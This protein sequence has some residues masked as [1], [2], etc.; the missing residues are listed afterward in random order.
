MK[1]TAI[2][3]LLAAGTAFGHHMVSNIFIDGIDQGPGTCLRPPPNTNP[4]KDL[5][6]PQIA[7]NVGGDKQ[8]AITCPANA[9]SKVTFKWRAWPS[10]SQDIPL[11]PSH[12][13][14]CSVYMKRMGN[15]GTGSASGGGWFKIWNDGFHDGQFCTERLRANNGEMT[16][17]IPQD[18]AGGYYLMRAE[19]LALHQ[20]QNIGGA[21]WYVGCAQIF[22]YS[23]G[24]EAKP[25]STV[26]IPGYA[27]ARDPGVLFDYWN[28]MKPKNYKIPGP[29]PYVKTNAGGGKPIK[30]PFNPHPQYKGC[31][32]KNANWCAVSPPDYTDEVS[33]WKTLDS[34]YK[35]LDF[36][37]HTAPPTG[38]AGCKK[39]ESMC[40]RHQDA[41]SKCGYGKICKGK[42]A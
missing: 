31:L 39:F 26:S 8:V 10:G 9:G 40:K 24:G 11:D 32:V 42:F 28:N 33:C 13:G 27:N 22:L 18:L 29:A 17:T 14:P 19:S 41:C 25:K 34:S 7:C 15:G 5:E 1:I 16:V 20:A 4:F 6:S 2:L 36:C 37:Y 35:Q 21:Q 38:Y 12:Q 30:V 23:T 3:S